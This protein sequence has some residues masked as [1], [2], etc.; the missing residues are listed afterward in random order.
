MELTP[1]EQDAMAANCPD[2]WAR[3]G[4]EC[5]VRVKN[6]NI[7]RK[8]GH[9]HPNRISRAGRRGILHG[10]GRILLTRAA[11]RPTEGWVT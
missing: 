8:R 10:A 11:Y 2:C 1:D 9:P 4:E 3:P 7:R 6:R 5:W